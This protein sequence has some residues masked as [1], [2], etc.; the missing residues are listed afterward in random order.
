[1]RITPTLRS[2]AAALAEASAALSA[3]AVASEVAAAADVPAA[4]VSPVSVLPHP[5]SIEQAVAAAS[6]ILRTFFFIIS[7]CYFPSI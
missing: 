5:A 1:M 6:T 3:V 2:D 4:A 7:S